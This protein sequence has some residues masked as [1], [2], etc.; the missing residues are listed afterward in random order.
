MALLTATEDIKNILTESRT[1][2]VLGAHKTESKPA[3]YVPRYL[4][5]EGYEIYPVN[6][7]FAGEVL[8]DHEVVS[9]LSEL[10]TEID[11]VEVFRRSE[12]LPGHVSDILAMDPL[13][14]VVWFQLGIQNDEAAQKLSEAGINVV[15]NK[16]MLAEHQR[17]L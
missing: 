8:H 11:I 2:A 12:H 7:T 14:K 17:L 16:C 10:D 4:K 9:N 15:Q 3:Y 6:P 13:P 1:I 5:T